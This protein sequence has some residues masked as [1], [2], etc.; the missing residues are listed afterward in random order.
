MRGEYFTLT[1]LTPFAV[2]ENCLFVFYTRGAIA[3][4]FMDKSK[5]L[6]MLF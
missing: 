6:E 3:E 2:T 1:E 4:R 5:M